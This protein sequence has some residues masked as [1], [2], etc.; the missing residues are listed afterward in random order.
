M[1]DRIVWRTLKRHLL[2][3]SCPGF[4]ASISS[5]ADSSTR[6]EGYN[7]LY[8][9]VEV[10]NSSLGLFS[11][12]SRG[13]RV[14]NSDIGRFS[15]IGP[16]TLVGGL[17]RHPSNW[18]STHPIFYSTARQTGDT[19]FA[20]RD[21]FEE[22]QR[23]KIGSDVWIG[24]RAVVLDGI[25]VGDGAIIAAGAIVTRN[26][27][28]Y[29]IVGGAPAKKIRDRFDSAI[30]EG[31]LRAEWWNWPAESLKE[32]ASLFRSDDAAPLLRLAEERQRK[33]G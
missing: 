6:F 32:A 18:L 28:P 23:T 5:Y 11:Y 13:A 22:L 12:L 10:Q 33:A 24:A 14:I 8:P 2:A 17:G 27:A 26:V 4:G 7:Q 30:I 3:R 9:L 20:E 31:L 21:Y 16:E 25:T 29:S 15:C 1:I 19:T